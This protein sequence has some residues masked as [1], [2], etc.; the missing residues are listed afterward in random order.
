MGWRIRLRVLDID[1][2]RRTNTRARVGAA[3]PF[4]FS[5][6]I[7]P[8]EGVGRPPPKCNVTLSTPLMGVFFEE[9]LR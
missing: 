2:P 4:V 1:G 9:L 5:D 3:I 8:L 7:R 6:R